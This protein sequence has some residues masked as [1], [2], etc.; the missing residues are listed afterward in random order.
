MKE[1]MKKNIRI[2]IATTL[3]YTRKHHNTV[4]QLYCNKIKQINK[5]GWLLWDTPHWTPLKRHCVGACRASLGCRLLTGRAKWF[6]PCLLEEGKEQTPV[7][8]PLGQH[9]MR[10]G[11]WPRHPRVGGQWPI[12]LW[13]PWRKAS[14][15]ISAQLLTDEWSWAN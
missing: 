5:S 2:R 10:G 9:C 7:G 1:K 4:N 3:L 11:R 15:W 14:S 13:R 8:C 12:P 6:C